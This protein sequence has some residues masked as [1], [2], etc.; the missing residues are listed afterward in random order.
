MA[1]AMLETALHLPNKSAPP[2]EFGNEIDLK[3]V[4]NALLARYHIILGNYDQAIANAAAVNLKS[5]SIF[6]FNPQNPNPIYRSGFNAVF[7]YVPKPLFGLPVSLQPNPADGRI[8]FY[9]VG[10]PSIGFGFGKSD[11][12]PLPIYLPGEMLLIQAEAYVKKGD[13]TNG[14]KFL[15]SVL[16]KRSIDDAFGVGANLPAY[17]GPVDASSLLQEIYKNRCIELFMSGM[18][19]ED[20]RRFNRPGPADPGSERTRTYYPFPLVERN[21]NPNTPPDPVN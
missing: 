16:R 1:I 11:A 5:K 6:I 2:A 13:L 3:N 7:G 9:T 19:M 12:D 15:D 21:G 8:S 18:K 10:N 4:M 14:K 20:G 17:G